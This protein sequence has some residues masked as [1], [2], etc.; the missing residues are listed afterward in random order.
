MV[1]W[2]RK[3][4]RP[5]LSDWWY[6]VAALAAAAFIL[7]KVGGTHGIGVWPENFQ[8]ENESTIRANL[9][10][11]GDVFGGLLNPIL[12]FISIILLIQTIKIS[13]STLRQ[14]KKSL[15]IS[16]D[17]LIATKEQL[18]A[19]LE[20]LAI[21]RKEIERASDA[22]EVISETQELQRI[23]SSFFEVF[24]LLSEQVASVY[25]ANAHNY[26]N[27]NAIDSA[28]KLIFD[29]DPEHIEA[30]IDEIFRNRSEMRLL[31][32]YTLMSFSVAQGNDRLLR[33]SESVLTQE[34]KILFCLH[35]HFSATGDAMLL[36]RFIGNGDLTGGETMI[37]RWN[38]KNMENFQSAMEGLN[39]AYHLA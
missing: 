23:E 34:I 25:D 6:L 15:S 26:S 33:Y 10:A 2:R 8:S 1:L 19:N 16:N 24:K 38:A 32:K 29:R 14:S 37:Y 11:L 20:E 12:T 18:K 13:Q 5:W 27:S 39:L 3:L 17:A 35:A 4:W 36:S 30:N 31:L 28:L 21:T 9:G 7:Y 22:Q